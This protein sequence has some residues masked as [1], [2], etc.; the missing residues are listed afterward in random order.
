M[1]CTAQSDLAGSWS[2][3]GL[4]SSICPSNLAQFA[5]T[6]N[7]PNC[8]WQSRFGWSRGAADA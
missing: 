3:I 8:R 5:E 1:E 2:M 6:L 4:G 7:S